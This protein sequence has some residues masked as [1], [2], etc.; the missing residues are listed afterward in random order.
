MRTLETGYWFP[1]T[2]SGWTSGLAMM[3]QLSTSCDLWLIDPC[4]CR[5]SET[6]GVKKETEQS[7]DRITASSAPVKLSQTM[8]SRGVEQREHAVC[9]VWSGFQECVQPFDI[10]LPDGL[11]TM[12]AP[13]GAAGLRPPEQD[14]GHGIRSGVCQSRCGF[15]RLGRTSSAIHQHPESID[16]GP[17]LL[18]AADYIGSICTMDT[19]SVTVREVMLP[20]IGWLNRVTL[21]LE[22]N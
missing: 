21:P 9:M 5:G 22:S 8:K 4:E 20:D 16:P 6:M 10:A 13:R 1:D 12:V 2:R 11:P 18:R 3:R 19:R 15:R 14:Q 17:T 7:K